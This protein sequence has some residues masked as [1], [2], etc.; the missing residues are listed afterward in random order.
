ML[1][2]DEQEEHVIPLLIRKQLH[3]FLHEQLVSK[4]K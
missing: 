3:M 4:Y 1:P 2:A